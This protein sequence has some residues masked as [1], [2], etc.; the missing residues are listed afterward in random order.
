MRQD[1][2]PTL[3]VVTLWLLLGLSVTA[4]CFGLLAWMD[5]RRLAGRGKPGATA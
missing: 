2:P 1:L 4:L 5:L 3:K